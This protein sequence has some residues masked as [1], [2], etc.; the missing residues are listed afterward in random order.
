MNI[1]FEL[2]ETAQE[3]NLPINNQPVLYDRC[4]YDDVETAFQLE[5]EYLHNSVL[6]WN[7]TC[8]PD[9]NTI[10]ITQSDALGI[11]GPLGNSKITF[12]F[13]DNFFMVRPRRYSEPWQQ[14]FLETLVNPLHLSVIAVYNLLLELNRMEHFAQ[15]WNIVHSIKRFRKLITHRSNGHSA[16]YFVLDYKQPYRLIPEHIIERFSFNLTPGDIVL[17][18]DTVGYDYENVIVEKFGNKS[19]LRM[20]LNSFSLIE[21][22]I[23]Y[24]GKLMFY[25]GDPLDH[26]QTVRDLDN[27]LTTQWAGHKIKQTDISN[28]YKSLSL[29]Y[30]KVGEFDT[31]YI[32][33]LENL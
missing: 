21:Q 17:F 6:L 2:N 33:S 14:R 11:H 25:C 15:L 13:E 4:L 24:D 12:E 10:D 29:G 7:S 19:A 9:Y 30:I 1:K 27:S 32:Q 18:N 22:H 20:T 8:A 16:K 23:A 5:L 3:L 28:P 31:S 26:A